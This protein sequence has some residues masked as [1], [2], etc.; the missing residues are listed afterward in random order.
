MCIL[1]GSSIGHFVVPA[2]GQ[3]PD[4]LTLADA[5]ALA[6]RNHPRI[7][8]ATF[9]AEA[10]RKVVDEARAAYLPVVAANVTGADALQ[11]STIAAGN[12]TTSSLSTRFASGV[13][14][15]QM[16]TDFGRTSSLVRSAR[17][18]AEAAND[19]L[20][21]VRAG[22]LLDVQT[23]YFEVLGSEA[24]QKAAQAALDSRRLTLRQV[25]AL[26]QSSLKSTLDVSFAQVLVSEAELAVYQAEDDVQKS[27][28]HLAAALG[29][30]HTAPFI[31]V[32]QDV[33]SVLNPDVEALVR[34]ALRD[35]PDLNVLQ[36]NSAASQEY[37]KA[38]KKLSY[39][40]VNILGAAGGIPEHDPT[41]ARDD[42]G[43]AGVNINIPVF[44]GG[45]FAA[46]RT[47]AALR[48]Q[49]ASKD[50]Q[51]LSVQISHEVRDAW[52][53]AN[54]TLRRLSVTQQL[55]NQANLALHLAQARYDAGLGSIVELNQAQLAQTSAEID[56]ASA[57]YDYLTRRASLD[58]AIGALR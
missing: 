56:A 54:Y 46:R 47:E 51:D 40:T 21:R 1:L 11:D 48:A 25:T 19:N 41:L 6:L 58:Y 34:Q 39:P 52:F 7:G 55:V 17:F 27:R 36:R 35:R 30:D 14:L 2:F 13:S 45:L 31:L 28:A 50:V 38:E 12:L 44:N 4:R 42:Y 20:T 22:I 3:T 23:A 32:D 53:D 43:A 15:L 49:A 57:K 9:T 10:T 16:V 26:A 33:P 8:S 24:V 29:F 5:E 37:A 18:R